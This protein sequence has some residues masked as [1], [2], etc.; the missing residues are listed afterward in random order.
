MKGTR[1]VL[2]VLIAPP[3][4]KETPTQ[5]R[6]SGGKARSVPKALPD[7]VIGG[8]VAHGILVPNQRDGVVQEG[9]KTT[10]EHALSRVVK[11]CVCEPSK[12]VAGVVDGTGGHANAG[13]GE[14]LCHIPL[15]RVLVV[16]LHSV[17]AEVTGRVQH[18][19]PAG[20]NGGPVAYDRWQQP[21]GG[22]GGEGLDPLPGGL[23]QGEDV[24]S[25]SIWGGVG[26]AIC[27]FIG[28]THQ[29]QFSHELHHPKANDGAVGHWSPP[30]LPRAV[31]EDLVGTFPHLGVANVGSPTPK[32]HFVSDSDGLTK[33]HGMGDI[34][35]R[36]PCQASLRGEQM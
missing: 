20:H 33:D 16:Q 36:L 22:H 11:L 32:V 30:I 9:R 31:A 34:G 25:E 5:G 3:Q 12:E 13:H 10:A 29:E 4:R 1:L 35:A 28:P 26:L 14:G 23:V 24:V 27:V 2:Q 6:C 17:H 8:T 19:S 15:P 18:K 21:R 7:R